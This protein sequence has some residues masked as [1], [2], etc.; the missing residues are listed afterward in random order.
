MTIGVDGK[1]TVEKIGDKEALRKS[2]KDEDWN[3]YVI[4]AN[5]DNLKHIVNGVLMSEVT[6]NEKGKAAASGVIAIQLHSGPPM[7]V[8]LKNIRL[9]ELK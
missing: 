5:G 6:D 3:D 7:K 9:K 4:L 1:R 8:Q 2:I